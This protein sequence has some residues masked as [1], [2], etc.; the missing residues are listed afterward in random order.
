MTTANARAQARIDLIE[1]D[2]ESTV[3]DLDNVVRAWN[4][5][6]GANNEMIQAANRFVD[7]STPS[8]AA[9]RAQLDP[10]LRVVAAKETA[11]QIA[12]MKFAAAAVRAR[13]DVG[14]GKP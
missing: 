10:R 9:I 3:G 4:E 7:E 13:R 5:W 2:G 14:T 1:G 12:V 6:L 11:F 8:G